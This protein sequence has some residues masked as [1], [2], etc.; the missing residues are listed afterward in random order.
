M[1]FVEAVHAL[2]KKGLLFKSII[3]GYSSIIYIKTGALKKACY[4]RHQ[5]PILDH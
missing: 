4:P 1:I 2:A 5:S 3:L